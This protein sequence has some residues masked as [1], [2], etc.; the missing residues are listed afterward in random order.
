MRSVRFVLGIGGMNNQMLNRERLK[1][2]FSSNRN[3]NFETFTDYIEKAFKEVGCETVF[4]EN[5]DFTIPGRIRDRFNFLHKFD[6]KI[7]NKRLFNIAKTFKPDLFLEDG[8]WNIL[9]EP[10]QT[11]KKMGVKTALWTNDPPRSQVYEFKSIRLSA[12]YYNF[13]FATGTEGIDGFKG[14]EIENLSLLPFACDSDFHKPVAITAEERQIY[15]FDVC[16]AGS[17]DKSVY[18]MRIKFLESLVDFRLGVW[19]PGWETLPLESPLRQ[20]I[21]GGALRPSKWIKL[22]SASKIVFHSHYRDPLD[23]FPNYQANPRVFEALACGSFLLVDDQRDVQ[24]LFKDGDHL[25]IYKDIED[26]RAK[27]SYYLKNDDERKRI[28]EN[29]R[30]EVLEKHTYRHRVKAILDI[31]GLGERQ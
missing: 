20:F 22:F 18:P 27:V 8:G 5:R 25:V 7:L 21:K 10:I 29:G 24:A 14:L 28:A 16:F 26:L 4:F 3:P 2:L 19:G 31:V 23:N 13:V 12:P 6:L 17:G 30:R 9:P 15:G 11:M 1:V